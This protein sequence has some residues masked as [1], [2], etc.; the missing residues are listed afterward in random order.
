MNA[1]LG[2]SELLEDEN[3][4]EPDKTLFIKLIRRNGEMLLNLIN[5]IID[6]SKIEADLLSIRKRTLELNKFLNEINDHYTETLASKKDKNIQ[7][8][9]ISDINPEVSIMT[10]EIRLRQIL[11]NLIGNAIKFTHSGNLTI[12]VQLKDGFVHFSVSDTGIGIPAS[13]HASIFE[14]FIQV[15]QSTKMNFGGTG[16]G[17]AI[18]KN[19]IELLGGKISVNSEPGVG[20]TFSFYIS[21][22]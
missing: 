4:D 5:D 22:H 10:D 8:K 20:S 7:F 19:L 12:H 15:E 6:I 18:S 14:R 21:A 3:Q 9:I 16:L 11:D 2:F 17:L 1:I 13:Q